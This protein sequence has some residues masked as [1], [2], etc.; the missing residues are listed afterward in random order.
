MVIISL[1][2]FMNKKLPGIILFAC[3]C[4]CQ[5]KVAFRCFDFIT[6]TVKPKMGMEIFF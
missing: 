5:P 1:L 2:R 4:L 6:I 3:Y